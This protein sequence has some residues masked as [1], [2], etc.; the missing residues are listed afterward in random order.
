V[1]E[2]GG[3]YEK[4]DV[5]RVR[6]VKSSKNNA[7]AYRRKQPRFGYEKKAGRLYS[8]LITTWLRNIKLSGD[9]GG[10][11]LGVNKV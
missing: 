1:G 9:R 4:G 2:K 6:D 7:S 10:G 8:K 3:E 11:W 5:K